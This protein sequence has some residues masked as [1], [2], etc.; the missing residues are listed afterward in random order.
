MNSFLD[1]SRNTE[2][3]RW[4]DSGDSFIVVD[5]DEFAKTLIPELFKHNNYAS[6]V[7]QL[8]MYGFHKKVGLS[9]NSMRA[10][11][12]KNKSPSEYS[13]PYFKQGRPNLLWLIQKPKNPQGKGA[14]KGSLRI[15]QEDGNMDEDG[16]EMFDGDIP[17]PQ[18]HGL[19]EYSPNVRNGRQPLMIDQGGGALPRGDLVNIQRELHAIRQNQQL[20]SSMLNRTREDHRKLYGQAAA[21]QSLHDRHESSIN[22]ILTFLATVYNRSLEG[23]GGPNFADMFANAIPHESQGQG[24]VVDVGEF[25]DKASDSNVQP[26]RLF[27][28]Q[29]LL[30]KAPP[31]NPQNGQMGG[32]NTASPGSSIDSPLQH[33]S[34]RLPTTQNQRYPYS[35][36]SQVAQSPAIQELTDQTHSNR[37]S[38]SPQI[39]PRNESSDNQIPE[40]DI[41]SMINSANAS[42]TS[43][44]TAQRMDFPQALS[45]L[46][47]ADGKSP[48]T[49]NQRHDVLQLMANDSASTARNN[50]NNAL[51]FPSPPHV[52]DMAHYNL[53]KDQL[54][55]IGNSLKDQEHKVKEL[56]QILAPLSPSGSIPGVN[57]SQAFGG[58][59]ML[60]LDQIF[61][62]GDYFSDG[63]GGNGGGGVGLGGND[64]DFGNGDD[65]GDFN[66]DASMA[67]DGGGDMGNGDGG[68]LNGYHTAMNGGNE[69]ANG[70]GNGSADGGRAASTVETVNSSEATSPA[71]TVDEGGGGGGG[72]LDEGSSP[73]KRR[74][75]RG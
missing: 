39:K 70:N 25:G 18:T 13:N 54:E 69:K 61:N 66:F 37:S 8:N 19:P 30:L 51:T 6:F 21:F 36:R 22:A 65:L 49:P 38:A 7:R 46:Q 48:L 67:P 11:E 15:K 20:I 23:Q 41:L 17:P 63:L 5:E 42:N 44:P 31:S 33:P 45:H 4:S 40:A 29:P 28:K 14:G 60:D 3:I 32:A 58:T 1:E 10:S 24:N 52:P 2:L 35:M 50:N 75:R 64:I 55:I 73:K 34:S 71:N 9:D 74:R 62:S 56:N 59:D 72:G 47:T 12:R 68:F 53:T 26:Q 16:D 43:F 57:D 27:R